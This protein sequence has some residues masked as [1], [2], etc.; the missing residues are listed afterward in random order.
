MI[1]PDTWLALVDGRWI[2]QH[3]LPHVDQITMWTHGVHWVDQ[4]WL[5][6]LTFYGIAQVGGIKL[7]V[8]AALALD[9]L[10]LAG[11]AFAARRLGASTS[12]VALGALIPIVVGPWLLQARTQSLALPL[13]VGVYALLALDSRKQSRSVY[14]TIPLLALW[15]NLHGSASLGAALVVLFGALELVRRRLRGLVLILAAPAALLASPY[16]LDLPGYYH[17]MLL[18]SQLRHYVLEWGPTHLDSGTAPFFALAFLSIYLLG[19]RGRAVSL[20]ERLAL[21]LLVVLGV[22]AA[23]NTIWLGLAAAISLPALFDGVLGPSLVLTQG[24]RRL[25]VVL[26]VGGVVFAALLATVMLTRPASVLLG[27]WPSAG[28]DA[29]AAAASGSGRVLGDDSHSNWLLWREPQLTGRVAYDV[30]F[31]LFTP[32]QL[33]RLQAFRSGTAPEV[34][35]GY[36]VL[37]FGD[38]ATARRAVPHGRVIYRSGGFVAVAQP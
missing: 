4:Q 36:R 10:A 3:G 1:V 26:S 21:P 6:Q 2:A 17:T 37:T 38:L 11:A 22:L 24:M 34:G 35:R 19:R 9:V 12:S 20:F 29:V 31:E 14:L 32:R 8:A 16:G 28:A 7:C 33:A 25:N 30:R 5:G 27:R 23:R 18:G 15:A 13:F